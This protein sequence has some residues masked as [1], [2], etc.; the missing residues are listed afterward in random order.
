MGPENLHFQKHTPGDSN[1][2]RSLRTAAVGYGSRQN[3]TRQT[4]QVSLALW[5]LCSDGK[6]L[7]EEGCASLRL[8]WQW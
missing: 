8:G 4:A 5:P 6:G 1:A 7:G 3:K 2:G